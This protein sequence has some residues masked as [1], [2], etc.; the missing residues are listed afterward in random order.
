M[1]NKL[2]TVGVDVER[3]LA[4]LRIG[5]VADLPSRLQEIEDLILALKG[6]AS[7]IEDYQDI[8]RHVHSIK[9]SAG[10]H[11]LHIISTVCHALEDKVIEIEG[12][13]KL[14]SDAFIETVLGYIDLLRTTLDLIND[15]IDDF[16]TIE[17]ELDQLSGKGSEYD[18]RGILVMEGVLQRKLVTNAFE[19]YPV[20]FSYTTNGY[21]ALGMLLKEPYD[22][23][24]T[25]MEVTDLQGLPLITAL[26]L[27]NSR[28]NDIPSVLL[29]SG[30]KQIDIKD[31]GP[32]YIVQKD[33]MML[34]SLSHAADKI[35]SEL[36]AKSDS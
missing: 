7:F 25:N 19:K 9:G 20:K 24:V 34:E 32:D 29:T 14:I 11:G 6:S 18:F 16:S 30:K 31:I 8:Y 21:D 10:T 36:K 17:V 23:L 1:S 13:Q 3:M 15:N 33:S 2:S 28:N 22:L 5:F 35:I 26:H 12:D 27:S 4:E